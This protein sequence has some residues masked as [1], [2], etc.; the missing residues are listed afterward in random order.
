MATIQGVYVA[1]FGRPADPTG[2]A[3]FNSVTSGGANLSAIGNLAATQEYQARFAGQNNVQIITAIYQSL[4]N[5]DPEAAGLNFFVDALNKGTLSVNNI[6]I[7]I[8]DGAQGSD[9][10]VVDA[11]VASANAFTAALD[12]PTE[13]ATYVGTN[14]ITAGQ[15]FLA[16]VSTT[17]KTSAQADTAISTLVTTSNTGN[18]S[19]ALTTGTDDNIVVGTGANDATSK[20]D[21]ITGTWESTDK[22]NGGFGVDTF[23]ATLTGNLTAAAGNIQNVEIFNLK[24]TA[25]SVVD[26]ANITGATQIWNASSTADLTV[27]NIA[28]GTTVGITGTEASATTF[29]FANATGSNDSATLA[30]N[31]AA[32]TGTVTI[33]AIENLTINNTGT[34]NAGVVAAADAKT[35]A[36]TGS[37]DLTATISV[38]ANGSIDASSHTGKLIFTSG[39]TVDGLK[40]VAGAS[41][42]TIN[43]TAGAHGVTVT[44]GAG[45][46]AFNFG[47]LTGVTD[48][49]KID[50]QVNTITDFSTTADKLTV[51]LTGTKAVLDNIALGNINGATTLQGAVAA[52]AAATAA[53]GY[54]VFTWHGDTYLFQNDAT[55][56]FNSG[57]GLL[58]VVGVSDV[59]ALTTAN[60]AI[61]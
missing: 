36:V 20:N 49:T 25:A 24:A 35:V 34:S 2:L 33:G 28:L 5:R 43:I 10:T 14:A 13:V 39:A 47:A 41:N 19:V 1:L 16:D 46:D 58:K 45:S 3:Y 40:V 12:T 51:G 57:D 55:A 8:L 18:V 48:V 9:R 6:A 11:K 37:G 7:A 31:A 44:G 50:T 29:N 27:S 59:A 15:S 42:D 30:V 60:F 23:N 21:I 32:N 54:A 38:A 4:F 26:V 53:S 17:A 56:G 22:V 61:A 52:A